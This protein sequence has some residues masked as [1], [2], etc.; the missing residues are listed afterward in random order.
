[1]RRPVKSGWRGGPAWHS[2]IVDSARSSMQQNLVIKLLQAFHQW[3]TRAGIL[4]ICRYFEA[5]YPQKSPHSARHFSLWNSLSNLLIAP[6]AI[7]TTPSSAA[8]RSLVGTVTD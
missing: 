1:M 6:L 2:A 3:L 8:A 4:V 7:V 5:E